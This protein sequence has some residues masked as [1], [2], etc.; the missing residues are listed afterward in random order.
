MVYKER[1]SSDGIRETISFYLEWL[2]AF[3][4]YSGTFSRLKVQCC[5][6]IYYALHIVLKL[7]NILTNTF[8][9]HKNIY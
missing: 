2:I 8:Q 9:I 4:L 7:E 3:I 5:Q 1:K 6:I